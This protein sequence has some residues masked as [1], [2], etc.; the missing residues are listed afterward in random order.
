MA[1]CTKFLK[2][3]APGTDAPVEKARVSGWERSKISAQDQK[4]LKK[5]GLLKKLES[6]KFPGDESFPH[7][8]IGFRL[9]QLTPNS[10]LHI[11]I[12]ITLC[13]CF[14]GIQP[15]WGLWKHIFYLRRNNSRNVIYNVGGICICVRPNVDY[16]D[17]KFPDSIQG[18]RKERRW[19]NPQLM[20]RLL[21]ARPIPWFFLKSTALLQKLRL[22][23]QNT[24]ASNHVPS[25]RAPLPKKARTGAGNT[26]EIVTGSTST[27]LLDDDLINLGSQFIGF[28]DEAATL[29]EAPRRAEERADALEAKLKSSETSRKKAEKDAAAV[30]GARQR[31]KTVEDALSEREARQIERE[32]AIVDR[33]DTQNRRFTRR[34]GE[35]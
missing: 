18:L 33:F 1:R 8:H 34:M 31:L 17:V 12:F 9:H 19:K 21:R 22:P 3:K 10:L 25:P 24:E 29:K 2:N 15:H 30:E 5:L 16:F 11:S 28:R 35:E 6:L 23:R 4:T 7:P 32:N 20:A 13:E 26:Q 27:P 14:L